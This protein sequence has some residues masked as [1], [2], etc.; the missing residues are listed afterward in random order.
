MKKKIILESKHDSLISEIVRDIMRELK[1]FSISDL[2]ETEINLP[3]DYEYY[4]TPFFFGETHTFFVELNLIKTDDE[5]YKIDADAPSDYEDDDIQVIIYFNPKLLKQ[6]FSEIRN[7]LYYTVRHE[8]EHLLQVITEYERVLYS[9]KH[10]F[11]KDS[12]ETLMKNTEIE[13]QIRGYFLQSKKERKPFDVVVSNHL[14]KLQK[15]GQINFL[16]EKR[17]N[18]V[19]EILVDFAKKMKLPIVLSNPS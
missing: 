5:N 2:D 11:K 12:L 8:Y 3:D 10:K 1:Y 9:K 19:I 14:D 7:N 15:N 13:P 6:Q 18:T 17:K 16:N 4:S